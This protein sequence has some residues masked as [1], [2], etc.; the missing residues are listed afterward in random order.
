MAEKFTE[1]NVCAGSQS[2]MREVSSVAET[3]TD[4]VFGQRSR[5]GTRDITKVAETSTKTNVWTG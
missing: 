3:F 2:E 1:K 5:N 4:K